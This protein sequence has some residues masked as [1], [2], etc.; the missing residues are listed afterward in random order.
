MGERAVGYVFLLFLAFGFGCAVTVVALEKART[1]IIEERRARQEW[2]K[3]EKE[4]LRSQRDELRQA[5][6][7]ISTAAQAVRSREEA[8]LAAEKEFNGRVITYDNLQTENVILKRDLANYHI[9]LQKAQLDRLHQQETQHTQKALA[10]DLGFQYLKDSVKWIRNSLSPNN[11]TSCKDRLLAVIERCRS[12]GC[13]VTHQQEAELI[14]ELEA[15]YRKIVKAALDREEQSRIKAQIREEQLREREIQRQIDQA[16]HEREVV[17]AALDAALA[18]AHDEHSAQVDEL[19]ARL[20]EAEAKTQRAMSQAQQTKSGHVYVIS[21]IGSF[22]DGVF[23]IGM[24][25]RL[26]PNER[27]KELGDASVPFPFDVHMMISCDDAPTL[28]NALH[29]AFHKLRVNRANPRKE[30]FKTSVDSIIEVVRNNH[31]EVEYVTDPEALEYRQSL[32][33]SDADQ[34]FI[35]EVFDADDEPA[36]AIE[37]A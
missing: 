13:A 30:F 1:T 25:R 12:I 6:D 8:F 3:T 34:E 22:G 28:E 27:I 20:A 19:R 23:K 32:S 2:T 9:H 24:T 35:E 17:Q 11:L 37:D 5:S 36:A 16:A 21:N 26:E 29:R 4:S 15:E 7:R 31:G 33:M 10:D 14:S 18:A